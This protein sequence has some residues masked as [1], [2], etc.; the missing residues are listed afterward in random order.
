MKY[1]WIGLGIITA[2]GISQQVATPQLSTSDKVA[3]QSL[4]EHKQQ[5]SKQ[6]NDAQQA[7]LTIVREWNA[8]HPGFH[9]NEQ[10]FIPEP[11]AKPAAKPEV[12]PEAKKIDPVPQPGKT[13]AAQTPK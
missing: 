12:K 6:Y 1:F 3:I 8:S 13:T 10:N 11:D 9:L 4:E 5:A 2:A 7:E